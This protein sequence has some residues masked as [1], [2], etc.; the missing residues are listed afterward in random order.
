SN[1]FQC[2]TTYTDTRNNK[3]YP[4]ALINGKCWFGKSLNYGNMINWNGAT[5][6]GTTTQDAVW[7][8]P[9][10]GGNI[11]KYC[12]NNDTNKCED[13]GALYLGDVARNENLCPPCW[14][15]A[16]ISEWE[17]LFTFAGNY[18]IRGS[19]L[20]GNA[21]YNFKGISS[22]FNNPNKELETGFSGFNGI[23]W[24]RNGTPFYINMPNNTTINMNGCWDNRPDGD[25]NAYWT[26]TTS[27]PSLNMPDMGYW[28]NRYNQTRGGVA[29]YVYFERLPYVITTFNPYTV[30]HTNGIFGI[31]GLKHRRDG[32]HHVR[33]VKN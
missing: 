16:S 17:Q 11:V 26:S 30:T 13:H 14:H 9:I 33:C 31:Q 24:C 23:N 25:Y 2:G 7:P 1:V 22:Q 29:H 12:A 18:Y 5:N 15:V 4:T 28:P 8:F 10:S 20:N 6:Y 3:V 21:P 32:A 27:T 19:K